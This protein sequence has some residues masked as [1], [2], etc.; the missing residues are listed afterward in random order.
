METQ[1]TK[2][3]QILEKGGVLVYP[4]DT[5]W[6]IGCDATD[7]NAV[8]RIFK[9]KQRQNS[10]SFIVL[11]SDV[12]MLQKYLNT[13]LSD[14]VIQ[15]IQDFKKP[16]TVIYS[17]PKDVAKNLIVTNG[18][19]AIRIAQDYFCKKLINQFNKPIVSTSANISKKQT[20][21]S[22]DQIDKSILERADYVVNLH[23]NKKSLRAS[24]ILKLNQDETFDVLRY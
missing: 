1:I 8:K 21:L 11:V 13:K 22:F 23:R 16:T 6:G 18:T 10:Q 24:L 19:L 15:T 3:L 9:L 12:A 4:T 2:S 14:S 5:V 7:A 17:N 20:P